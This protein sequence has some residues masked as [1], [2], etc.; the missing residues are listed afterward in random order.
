MH[1]DFHLFP[2]SDLWL[3]A[4]E[5]Q[6]DVGTSPPWPDMLTVHVNGTERWSTGQSSGHLSYVQEALLAPDDSDGHSQA[7]VS[8]RDY[9]Q[10]G[11]LAWIKIQGQGSTPES[12]ITVEPLLKD[13]KA[14]HKCTGL[15]ETS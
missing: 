7:T 6:L 8:Y 1:F 12:C 10:P 5:I 15:S 13:I 11:Q 9:N 2:G 4:F 3:Q 14:L